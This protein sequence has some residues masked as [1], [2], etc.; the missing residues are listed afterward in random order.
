M[1]TEQNNQHIPIEHPVLQN[2]LFSIDE[3]NSND[4]R[5]SFLKKRTILYD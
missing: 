2:L 1:K 3:G 5:I 4:V